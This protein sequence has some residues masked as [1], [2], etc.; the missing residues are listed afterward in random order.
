[1][2]H[3]DEAKREPISKTATALVELAVNCP[4]CGREAPALCESPRACCDLYLLTWFR[5]DAA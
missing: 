3:T 4:C 1:M 2:M 5:C